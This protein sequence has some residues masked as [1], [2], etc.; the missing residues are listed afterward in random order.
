MKILKMKINTYSGDPKSV[1][2]IDI[3]RVDSPTEA[4]IE[5][6]IVEDEHESILDAAKSVH[7][8]SKR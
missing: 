7:R 3:A 5:S 1:T 8:V 4:D 2:R 6:Q